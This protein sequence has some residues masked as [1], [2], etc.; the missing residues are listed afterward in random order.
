MSFDAGRQ[1]LGLF[2]ELF[3]QHRRH[4]KHH[5]RHDHHHGHHQPWASQRTGRHG[6]ERYAGYA[7]WLA[8]HPGAVAGLAFVAVLVLALAIAAAV[9]L[10]PVAAKLLGFVA[11][12]GVQGVVDEAAR[13]GGKLW[14]GGG[15]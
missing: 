14:Y 6:F 12:N 15:R 10:W 1:T 13:A 8:R 7:Q 5:H 9:A 11:D 2:D 4:S 3:E